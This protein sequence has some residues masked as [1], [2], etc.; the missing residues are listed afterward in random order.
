MSKY[1]NLKKAKA[2]RSDRLFVFNGEPPKLW[3]VKREAYSFM[4]GAG[5]AC[6]VYMADLAEQQPIP[7]DLFTSYGPN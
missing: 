7:P 3:V 1:I 5:E 4:T 6:K 2:I